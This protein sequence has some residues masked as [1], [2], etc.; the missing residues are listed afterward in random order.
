LGDVAIVIRSGSGP[1][2]RNAVSTKAPWPAGH[3]A[4]PAG[5]C[6]AEGVDLCLRGI[7]GPPPSTP[8]AGGTCPPPAT[9]P[10][11]LAW[12][13]ETGYP[14]YHDVFYYNPDVRSFVVR[15]LTGQPP[16]RDAVITPR[17][18]VGLLSFLD[19]RE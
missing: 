16:R 3:Y 15:T 17:E 5:V 14:V 1:A 4:S 18:L 13:H 10:D 9:L 8:P 6:D 19:G 12:S 7:C 11:G 2:W